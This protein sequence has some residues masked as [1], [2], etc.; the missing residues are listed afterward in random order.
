MKTPEAILFF[1]LTISIIV[2]CNNDKEQI[3]TKKSISENYVTL[4][5]LF[6]SSENDSNKIKNI[7][8]NNLTK[9]KFW[10][11]ANSNNI[12]E[13][14]GFEFIE[15]T[16]VNSLKII[17]EKSENYSVV[18]K[19]RLFVDDS[20]FGDFE[21]EDAIKIDA[22]IKKLFF[23]IIEVDEKYFVTVYI[24]SLEHKFK[25]QK[26]NKPAKIDKIQITDKFENKYKISAN[27]KPV[28]EN[29]NSDIKKYCND[30]INNQIIDFGF[31]KNSFQ[32][33]SENKIFSTI[34]T[35]EKT[36]VLIGKATSA[37]S[38]FE[39]VEID[40]SGS[41][42][43]TDNKLTTT[44]NVHKTLKISKS[45]IEIDSFLNMY[46]KIPDEAFVRV[47]DLDTSLILDIRYATLNNFTKTQLYDCED[48]LLRY[49]VALALVEANNFLLD[50]GYKLKLFDCYRPHSVQYKM[51]EAMPN[52]N[53]VANPEKGS[54]HNRGGAVDIT[55]TDL[56]NKELDMGTEYD[57]FG[58]EAFHAYLGFNDTILQN[59]LLLKNSLEKFNFKAI[60]TEWWHYSH[61]TC[62]FY[63]VSNFQLPCN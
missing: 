43:I 4:S 20:F 23:Q 24:D 15:K 63:E 28:F 57:F 46:Y 2:S 47:K 14:I 49:T 26:L 5:K 25:N 50:L 59:R 31:T 39:T 40:F 8:E 12:G 42:Y 52:I 18:K 22:K 9:N 6:A 17:S 37:K 19:I 36:I 29:L 10:C 30:I 45:K 54:I 27:Y 38:G 62:I 21:I 35:S 56:K 55:V 16:Y 11:S 1:V 48:C 51:W 44:E 60:K 41:I 7:F 13:I 58:K 61:S 32:I 53:F 33:N 34:E 3:Q